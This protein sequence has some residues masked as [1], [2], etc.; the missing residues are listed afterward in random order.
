MDD[1]TPTNRR[2]FLEGASIGGATLLAG[3]TDQLD[4][5]GQEASDAQS[6]SPNESSSDG[7]GAIAAVDQQ[8]MQEEQVRLQEEIQS[9]NLTQEEAREE[10]ATIQSEYIEEAITAL[11]DAAEAQEGVSVEE[12]YDSFGAVIV[13]GDAGGILQLLNSDEVSALVSQADIEAQT[14]AAAGTGTAEA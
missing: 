12:E 11:T 5:G 1:L 10:Y 8:A 2:R 9:G 6:E 7:V 14:Q 13:S 4:L 3:C